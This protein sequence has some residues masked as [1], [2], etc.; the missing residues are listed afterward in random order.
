VPK[1]IN[2]T[3]AVDLAFLYKEKRGKN[4]MQEVGVEVYYIGMNFSRT[5]L[6]YSFLGGILLAPFFSFAQSS[7]SIG[8]SV[9]QSLPSLQQQSLNNLL[10]P[11]NTGGGQTPNQINSDALSNYLKIQTVPQS[12]T[13]GETIRVTIESYLTDLNKATVSWTLNGSTLLSGVG[14]KAFSFQNGKNGSATYLTID[15][16][17]NDGIN[18]QKRLSWNPVGVT[19]LW[20][21]NTYTPPF[22][23]GKALASYQARIR[24]VAIP[25]NTSG[26]NALNA[27]NL[28]Y[29]WQKDGTVAG[30]SSGY[31]KNTFTFSAPKPYG[32]TNVKVLASSIDD[33]FSSETKIDLP[34]TNPFILFYENLPLLGIWYNSPLNQSTTLTKKEISLSA[35]PYFFSIDDSDPPS[36]AY[37]W[38]VNGKRTQSYGKNIILRNEAGGRGDSIVS[39]V[40]NN[41]K[42]TFQTAS[43]K[44]GIHFGDETNG[45]P[46]F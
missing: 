1:K 37:N 7:P 39:L 43:R 23:R 36:L 15:I 26:Q 20:Q 19:I 24:A 11:G 21:A 13:P 5:I 6:L 2:E 30:S 9:D 28:T 45:T 8:Q 33:T 31:K 44:L 42:Q 41:N 35:E 17:T 14:K 25:D 16:T 4:T 22:Y 3:T 27:G 32:S 46:A 29:T 18:I 38:S 12:P 40:M 10:N 34:I